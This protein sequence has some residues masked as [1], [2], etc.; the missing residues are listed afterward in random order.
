MTP[1]DFQNFCRA[2][3]EYRRSPTSGMNADLVGAAGM[4]FR[5][6]KTAPTVKL[7]QSKSSV[8]GLSP[9]IRPH[10][11]FARSLV[12]ADRFVNFNSLLFQFPI[13]QAQVTF[14]NLV[15]LYLCIQFTQDISIQREQQAAAGFT[16]QPVNEVD[17]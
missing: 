10:E 5:L 9:G 6:G 1:F 16:I 3:A 13:Q 12:L 8:R 2:A 14:F 11:V 17:I 15:V 4:Q 7:Q